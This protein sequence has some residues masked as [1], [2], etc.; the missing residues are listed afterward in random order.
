MAT[1]E[2]RR[3]V[4][5]GAWNVTLDEI[6][7]RGPKASV[8]PF[9]AHSAGLRAVYNAGL[10]RAAEIAREEK[11]VIASVSAA[12]EAEGGQDA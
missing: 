8:I 12:I 10:T 5:L 4:Y 6:R 11:F 7:E 2:E 3:A 9:E 1:D